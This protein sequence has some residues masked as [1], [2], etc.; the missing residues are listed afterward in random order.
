MIR[1]QKERDDDERGHL[2]AQQEVR[3]SEEEDD[4][5]S[6][7]TDDHQQRSSAIEN[8][9]V[10]H[11][12]TNVSFHKF[13][14]EPAILRT[15]SCF[16]KV[17]L[18]SYSFWNKPFLLQ[19][20][21]SNGGGNEELLKKIEELESIKSD[22]ERKVESKTQSQDAEYAVTLKVRSETGHSSF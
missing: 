10:K 22:L 18:G 20:I 5:K 8:N 1:T 6:T 7:S 12:H 14:G 3:T 4:T 21:D 11:E 16:A 9:N 15:Q 13:N 19:G 2:H 17:S